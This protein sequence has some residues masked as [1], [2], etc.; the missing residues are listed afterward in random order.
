MKS[1]LKGLAFVALIVASALFGCYY[2]GDKTKDWLGGF[3]PPK[4]ETEQT[5]NV[6]NSGAILYNLGV[7]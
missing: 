1:F 3:L 7:I 4:T 5:S 2:L 6:Q